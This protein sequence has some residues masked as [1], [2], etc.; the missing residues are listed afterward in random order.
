MKIKKITRQH[1]RDFEAVFECEH[2][3]N[4][5]ELPGY[6]DKKFHEEVIPEM[7]CL[8]CHGKA[9]KDYVPLRPKY[10]EWETV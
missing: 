7:K 10:E 6:D 2:C 4:E 5:V 3:G 8:E 1:R 9:G